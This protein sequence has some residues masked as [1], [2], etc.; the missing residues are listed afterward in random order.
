MY[1]VSLHASS[2]GKP[3][4]AWPS[5]AKDHA[6]ICERAT[7]V[8]NYIYTYEI[9]LFLD[10][11]RSSMGNAYIP[12]STFRPIYTPCHCNACMAAYICATFISSYSILLQPK[13]VRISRPLL[14][15]CFLNGATIFCSDKYTHQYRELKLHAKLF[16]FF[17]EML[18][19]CFVA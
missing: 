2:V 1:V 8:T 16:F 5:G 19:R 13:C 6:R 12:G 18:R 17:E 4:L 9:E 7:T 3:L 15:I 10:V 14:L 11:Y